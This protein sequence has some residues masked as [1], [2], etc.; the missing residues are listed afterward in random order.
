MPF[1]DAESVSAAIYGDA[2]T[3]LTILNRMLA[4]ASPKSVRRM[5]RDTWNRANAEISL[6]PSPMQQCV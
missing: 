4:I 5:V 2:A 3:S 1:P 6:L